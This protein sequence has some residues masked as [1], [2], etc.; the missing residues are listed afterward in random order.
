MKYL[1]QFNHFDF[2]AFV[3][4]KKL[5]VLDVRENVD[6]NTKEHIGT[7]VEA[8][9]TEDATPYIIPEG[10]T[11]SSN[12]Y[13]KIVFKLAKDIKVPIGARITVKNAVAR[14]YGEYN[15]QLAVTCEDIIVVEQENQ[16]EKK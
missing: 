9:I 15:N 5:E 13:E 2:E 7:K 12:K 3:K 14:I 8:V 1:N 6:Y 10:R 4:G 11:P 16:N